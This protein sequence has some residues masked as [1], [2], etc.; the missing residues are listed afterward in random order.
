M[1]ALTT[2]M[3]A[4]MAASAGAGLLQA[5]VQ[6]D[7]AKEAKKDMKKQEQT[8]RNLAAVD[9]TA[10]DGGADITLGTPDDPSVDPVTGL[11]KK[12]APVTT[13]SILGPPIV[14]GGLR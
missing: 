1:G 7:A 2:L 5:K 10:V 12:K 11:K 8:A 4:S 13:A 9:E 6:Q 14:T 3:M